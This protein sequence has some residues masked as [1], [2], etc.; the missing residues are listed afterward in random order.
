MLGD[1]RIVRVG[2]TFRLLAHV[3]QLKVVVIVTIEILDSGY[4]VPLGF[5]QP[6]SG[7]DPTADSSNQKHD[8]G[9]QAQTDYLLCNLHDASTL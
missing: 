4:H 1:R 8:R 6:A 7:R 2:D 9:E 5:Y 3:Q